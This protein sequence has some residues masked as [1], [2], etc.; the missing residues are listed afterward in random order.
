MGWQTF[1]GNSWGVV[2]QWGDYWPDHAKG[3]GCVGWWGGGG[4]EWGGGKVS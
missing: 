2:F 1:S 4:G 3:R